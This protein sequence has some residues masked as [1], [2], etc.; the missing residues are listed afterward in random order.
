LRKRHIN[1]GEENEQ[2]K[3]ENGDGYFDFHILLMVNAN[4]QIVN[5]VFNAKA[6]LLPGQLAKK[7]FPQSV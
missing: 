6:R 7:D 1:R 2:E 4:R 3:Q 5:R